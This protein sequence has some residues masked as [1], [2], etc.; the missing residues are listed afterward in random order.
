MRREK[1]SE[2]GS[3]ATSKAGQTYMYFVGF[4]GTK[5][6]STTKIFSLFGIE[7]KPPARKRVLAR[8]AKLRCAMSNVLV[9]RANL[10][11]PA[12][13]GIPTFLIHL[14]RGVWKSCRY[15][16]FD[17]LLRLRVSPLST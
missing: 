8:G 11:A 7:S 10:G 16:T 1:T 17:Q 3:E 5:T 9:A 6:H 13:L 12:L 15:H 2:S 14:S 4:I